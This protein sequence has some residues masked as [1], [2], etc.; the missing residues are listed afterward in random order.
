MITEYRSQNAL[1]RLMFKPKPLWACSVTTA[2]FF[3]RLISPEIVRYRELSKRAFTPCSLFKPHVGRKPNSKAK[4]TG[5]QVNFKERVRSCDEKTPCTASHFKCQRQMFWIKWQ[6]YVRHFDITVYCLHRPSFDEVLSSVT[7]SD[8]LQGRLLTKLSSMS[9]CRF[10][11]FQSS[12]CLLETSS[13]S[14]A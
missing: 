3:T 9:T 1:H 2:I 13:W 7:W 10:V 5:E 8:Y 6:D 4:G 14:S 12:K 11:D